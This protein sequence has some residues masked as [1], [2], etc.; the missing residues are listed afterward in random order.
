MSYPAS[1]LARV[2]SIILVPLL[3]TL[4]VFII[5]SLYPLVRPSNQMVSL[6]M[7]FA[8]TLAT[9]ARVWIAYVLAVVVAVPL[10]VLT[11]ANKTLEALLLPI[12]DV[13][14]SVPILALFPAIIVLFISIGFLNGAA[15]AI[16]FLNMLWNIVFAL[17]GG[18]RIIPKDITYAAQV[19]GLRGLTYVRR[20]SLPAIFPQF[21]TG[22]VLAVADGWNIVIVAEAI[23]TYIP[24][25]TPASD[26]FGIGSVLVAGAAQGNNQIVFMSM[27]VMVAAIALV[28]FFVWQKLLHYAQRFRFE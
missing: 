12:F 3:I 16:L 26:L 20:V 5:Y 23:H 4:V 1:L 8:A 18:L 14:Q 27:V 6:S 22:S 7:L 9:M 19:F 13:L 11:I 2:Y 21:V 15:I 17:V 10:A 24:S 25:G 28:N